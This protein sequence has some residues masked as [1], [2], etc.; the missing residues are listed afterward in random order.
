[1]YRDLSYI[2]QDRKEEL[3]KYWFYSKLSPL[4]SKLFFWQVFYFLNHLWNFSFS[5]EQS[6]IVII[7][8]MSSMS[9]ILTLEMNFQF[10][11]TKKSHEVGLV[12]MEYSELKWLCV[13]SKTDNH[14]ILR[15][16]IETSQEV[17]LTHLNK[18]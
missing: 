15:L 12:I 8:S 11:K 2:Y 7:L 17:T 5:T 14:K 6:C 16:L 9:S 18:V 3:L 13:L 1:M 4:C 10:R